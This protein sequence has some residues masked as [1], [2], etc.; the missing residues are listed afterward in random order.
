MNDFQP[1]FRGEVFLSNMQDSNNEIEAKGLHVERA[2]ESTSDTQFFF[3]SPRQT[4]R[5]V[6]KIPTKYNVKS[7]GLDLIPVLEGSGSSAS[8]NRKINVFKMTPETVNRNTI[9]S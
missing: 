8:T 2:G 6:S 1:I 3:F 4:L 9:A 7:A 5:H